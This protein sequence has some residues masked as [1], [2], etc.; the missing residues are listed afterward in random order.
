MR[1][2]RSML[3][4]LAGVFGR[5]RRDDDLAAEIEAHLQLHVDDNLRAGMTPAEA[6]RDARIR[7]GG[8]DSVKERYRDQRGIPML[9]AWLKDLRHAARGLRKAPTFTAMAVATLAL[10][11][12]ANTAI[13]TVVDRVL[14]RPLPYPD[15]DRLATIARHVERNGAASDQFSQ[16]GRAWFACARARH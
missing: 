2:L 6:R 14:L 11:I 16:N 5:A 12:G 7:L 10:G 1:R 15:P 4:S 3:F 8:V 13:F 9:E